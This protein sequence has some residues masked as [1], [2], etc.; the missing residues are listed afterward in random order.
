MNRVYKPVL[1]TMGSGEDSSR[2]AVWSGGPR[3]T[4]TQ[5]TAL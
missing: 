4:V 5:N 1:F 3:L 2:E